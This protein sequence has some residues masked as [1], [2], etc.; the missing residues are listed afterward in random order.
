MLSKWLNLSPQN[1]S[2]QHTNTLRLTHKNYYLTNI[3]I[4]CTQ[5]FTT[6]SKLTETINS[7]VDQL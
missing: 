5:C 1:T 3:T 6:S 2:K 7:S 4:K